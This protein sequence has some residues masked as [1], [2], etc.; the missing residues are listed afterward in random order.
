MSGKVTR[1]SHIC[2]LESG[3][4][5]KFLPSHLHLI[6]N[7]T[8]IHLLPAVQRHP[9]FGNTCEAPGNSYVTVVKSPPPERGDGG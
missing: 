8:E 5:R 6:C 7:I 4:L 2:T 9:W 3:A 1:E